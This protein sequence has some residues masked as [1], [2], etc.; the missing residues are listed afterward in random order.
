MA[1]KLDIFDILEQINNKNVNFYEKLT[2]EEQKNLQPFV[3][4]RWITGTKDLRQVYFVNELVNRFVFS[5]NKHKN[6]LWKLIVISSSGVNRRYR[7]TKTKSRKTTSTPMVIDVIKKS[8]NYNTHD[9]I[10]AA[11]LIE[12]VD[13]LLL[14]DDLGLQKEE[15][16]KLKKELKNRHA[17]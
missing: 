13:I 9:A 5:L 14:A 15:I 4:M 10:Q 8:Y 2:P 17:V 11:R 12:D 6:L 7:W 1:N 3:I 16:T